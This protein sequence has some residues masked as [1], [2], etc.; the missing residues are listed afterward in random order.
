MR[1]TRLMLAAVAAASLASLAWAPAGVLAHAELVSSS[2]AAGTQLD[3]PPREVTL[4]FEG[5]LQP[6]GSGFLVTRA[7][8]GEVGTGSL[9]LDVAERN[10]IS[11]EV[12]ITQP[13]L[14]L[15]AWTA[16][17]LDGHTAAGEFSFR[18]GDPGTP[19][20]TAQPA[21]E[22][23]RALVVAGGLLVALSFFAAAWTAAR[24]ARER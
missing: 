22:G 6:D 12:T 15:V 13:G 11:G 8:A 5:E 7:G 16:V 18:Y 21:P 3:D 1:V 10:V 23:P 9:D 20:D 24:R 17:A 4:T 14:Y 2:P 19:P